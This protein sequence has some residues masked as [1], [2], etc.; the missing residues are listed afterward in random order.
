[1][2]PRDNRPNINEPIKIFGVEFLELVIVTMSMAILFMVG[3]V[4]DAFFSII[5]TWYFLL[6]LAIYIS[7]IVLL[8]FGNRQDQRN[9]LSSFIGYHFFQPKHVR[10][11]GK[12]KQRFKS[13]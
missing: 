11:Y 2:K 8:R 5:G 9:F 7:V 13:K 3:A 4:I 10:F 6:L 12:S 1:M